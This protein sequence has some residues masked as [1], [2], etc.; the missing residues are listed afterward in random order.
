MNLLLGHKSLV[1]SFP[2]LLFFVLGGSGCFLS[3]CILERQIAMGKE[4]VNS[5]LFSSYTFLLDGFGHQEIGPHVALPL[6]EEQLANLAQ[7]LHEQL[8]HC[9]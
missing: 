8:R 9:S 3:G 6:C 2:D 5:F 1:A 4:Q 7:I